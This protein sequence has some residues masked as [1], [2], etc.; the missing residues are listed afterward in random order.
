MSFASSAKSLELGGCSAVAT[1][2]GYASRSSEPI[3]SGGVG[4]VADGEERDSF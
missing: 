4:I 2:G 1:I 3:L